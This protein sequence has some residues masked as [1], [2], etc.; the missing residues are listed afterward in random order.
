MKPPSCD[1]SWIHSSSCGN[2]FNFSLAVRVL[3][4]SGGSYCA[5]LSNVSQRLRQGKGISRVAMGDE[6]FSERLLGMTFLIQ[7]ASALPCLI[8]KSRSIRNASLSLEISVDL[9]CG[10]VSAILNG[11]GLVGR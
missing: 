4:D 11:K 3:N 5:D 10:C 9:M 2:P 6:D 7:T 8:V 1:C